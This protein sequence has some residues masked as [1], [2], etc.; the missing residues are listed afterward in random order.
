MS[1]KQCEQPAAPEEEILELLEEEAVAL[2]PVVAELKQCK[3]QLL[4]LAAEY[5][6]YRKRS[7]RE[8]EESHQL[9]RADA[10][11]AFL[12][13]LDNF[14]RAIRMSASEG[15][16]A[17]EPAAGEY[18]KGVEMIYAQL[19]DVMAAQGAQAFGEAGESFDPAFHNA[20][21]HAEDEALG[22][23]IVAE[24]FQ[25]G[26]RMGGRVLRVAAVKVAN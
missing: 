14:E 3:E 2:D 19:L 15:G 16:I 25:K 21:M 1:N 8:R 6:N 10:L 13:V 23:N 7:Q 11:K 4:R 20:V 5:D 26:W 12:P 18:R 9:A 22:E 24:V 17:D